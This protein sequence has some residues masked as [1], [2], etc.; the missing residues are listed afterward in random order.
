[1]IVCAARYPLFNCRF[2]WSFLLWRTRHVITNFIHTNETKMAQAANK[3]CE[4]C[5]RASSLHYCTQCDQV[6]CDDCKVSHLRLKLCKYHHFITKPNITMEKKARECTYHNEDFI[7]LCQ[8]CN[9]LICK[10][11]VTT[12]HIQHTLRDIKEIE[13]L[14]GNLTFQ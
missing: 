11:C 12:T 5:L 3:T 14:F 9:Q 4:I 13:K 10:S 1:M 6:F 7:F 2:Y 8:H